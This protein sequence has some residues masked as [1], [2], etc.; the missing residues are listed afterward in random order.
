[1]AKKKDIKKSA[2][3]YSENDSMKSKV[4]IK[5]P[6]PANQERISRLV[7]SLFIGLGVLLVAFG[8]FSYIKYR[9]DPL[10][11]PELESP[12][13]QEVTSITNGDK[14]LVK[15]NAAGYDNV[16]VYVNDEKVG[17]VK[18]DDEGKYSFEYTLE[19]EGEYSIAVAG[20][21]G[22]P[23]RNISPKSDSMISVIDRSAPSQDSVALK[24]GEETNKDTF[25][26]VG[27]TEPNASVQVKR[28]TE[29]YNGLADKDGNFRIEGIS[30]DEGKNVFAV[31][32]KDV[33]GNEVLL[34]E[35][36]RVAYSPA[37]SVNGD[38]V[39]DKNIPQA[40]GTFDELIGNE[41]MMLFGLIAL[42]AF[43]SSSAVVYLKNKR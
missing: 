42:G 5:K 33:A 37:G 2:S 21:K 16:F 36:V 24:Y 19:D 10:L 38:A 8:I 6:I 43:I 17:D 32:I 14:I 12:A 34:E 20:V 28:G 18:V 3:R 40:A 11:D 25:I 41:L 31:Y 30:L 22:F 23:N 35:K 39:V 26:L 7:G 15:G 27:T 13:L 9:E 29:S 4:E 1:M